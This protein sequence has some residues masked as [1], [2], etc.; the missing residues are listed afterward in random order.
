MLIQEVIMQPVGLD[1]ASEHHY[2][3]GVMTHFNCSVF[4]LFACGSCISLNVNTFPAFACALSC[5][6]AER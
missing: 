6:P 5:G 1:L 3:V 2:L 4:T